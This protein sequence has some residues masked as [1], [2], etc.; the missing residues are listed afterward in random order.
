MALANSCTSRRCRSLGCHGTRGGCRRSCWHMDLDQTT[1]KTGGCIMAEGCRSQV[2][3]ALHTNTAYLSANLHC[4][5]Q[6]R[7]M[8]R[9]CRLLQLAMA[10]SCSFP[11]CRCLGCQSTLQWAYRR[12]CQSMDLEHC[13]NQQ[14]LCVRRRNLR[15]C[16]QSTPRRVH[17]YP[18]SPLL[19]LP[20]PSQ[21]PSEQGAP[22]S[23][24]VVLQ[25][26]SLQVALKHSGGVH[27][28]PSQRSAAARTEQFV[29][30]C[31]DANRVAT[32]STLNTAPACTI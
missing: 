17:A 18:A 30:R 31:L 7:H 10:S 21:R 2:D 3:A 9:R 29:F 6:R 5:C 26:P 4:S 1:I 28:M 25:A 12:S 13:C 22:A 32:P 16:S 14:V 24:G 27:V 11:R 19:Q 20:T 23:K 15:L 8:C